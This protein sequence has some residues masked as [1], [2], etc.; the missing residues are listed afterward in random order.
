MTLSTRREAHDTQQ[1]QYHRD[2]IIGSGVGHGALAISVERR[3]V[4]Y[5]WQDTQLST[6]WSSCERLDTVSNQW[7]PGPPM[8]V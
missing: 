2:A 8:A 4:R 5:L 3:I 7:V 1:R 6:Q